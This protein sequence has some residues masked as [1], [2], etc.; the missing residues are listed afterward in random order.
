[1]KIVIYNVQLQPLIIFF[2]Y[3]AEPFWEQVKLIKMKKNCEIKENKK[4]Q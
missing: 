2:S 4:E 3:K 1:M